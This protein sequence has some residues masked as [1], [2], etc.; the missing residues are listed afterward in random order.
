[1][2][3]NILERNLDLEEGTF[4][5]EFSENAVFTKEKLLELFYEIRMLNLQPYSIEE[6]S[7][8][9]SMVWEICFLIQQKLYSNLNPNDSFKASGLDLNECPALMNR[10][11]YIGN[12]FAHRKKMDM[13]Y[14][15][16]WNV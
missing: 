6:H 10:L 5:Y 15:V 7:K 4:L 11:H 9:S 12:W 13:E 2:N 3:K 1:M 8:K 14:L 16:L